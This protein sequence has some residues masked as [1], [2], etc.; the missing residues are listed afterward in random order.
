MG[1]LNLT[2]DSF[3][4][5]GRFIHVDDA[6]RQAEQM[7][8]AGVDVLDL[9]AESTRPG[10]EPVGIDEELERLIPVIERLVATQD[11]LL[12]IDTSKPEVMQAAVQAGAGMINDVYALRKP[13]ALEM[14]AQL[15]VPVCLMHMQGTSP[16]TMQQEISASDDVI[17]DIQDFFYARIQACLSAGLDREK[18]I[19]D[20]GFGFGKTV[21]QNLWM[22]QQL[23]VFQTHGLPVLLGVSRKSTIGVVLQQDVTNRLFGGLGLAIF[24]VLQGV[25]LIRTHDVAASKQAIDMVD[26]VLL[27]KQAE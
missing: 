13:G 9:G 10:A 2:L 18:L 21:A 11:V 6:L 22:T 4:D 27:A 3:S 8:E 17:S 15:D 25:G 1:V 14:A 19:L 16:K 5:G 26:A 24:A 7:L 20:P 23:S 12:S